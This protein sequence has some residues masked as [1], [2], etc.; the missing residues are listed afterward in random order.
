MLYMKFDFYWNQRINV[1]R[2][3]RTSVLCSCSQ[4]YDVML[5]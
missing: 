4:W 5:K 1:E 3:Y 2:I